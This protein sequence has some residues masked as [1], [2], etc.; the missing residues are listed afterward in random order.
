MSSAA[1]ALGDPEKATAFV[2]EGLESVKDNAQAVALLLG[3]AEVHLSRGD[4]EAFMKTLAR[5]AKRSPTRLDHIATL[6][7]YKAMIARLQGDLD[8]SAAL[9]AT[10]AKKFEAAH[11]WHQAAAMW[12]F[13]AE[14]AVE[15]NP[16]GASEALENASR[17]SLMSFSA[18]SMSDTRLEQVLVFA[19]RSASSQSPLE[20]ARKVLKASVEASTRA[21]RYDQQATALRYGLLTLPATA[22]I[23]KKSK[24]LT[25]ALV[26]AMAGT[27]R[28]EIAM[29]L[30]LKGRLEA[31]RFNFEG[32]QE[33]LRDAEAFAKATG[34]PQLVE[35]IRAELKQLSEQ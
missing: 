33:T 23:N 20:G 22:D 10:S 2:E 1:L 24:I 35:M 21:E 29:L 12:R 14:T 34:D 8:S 15:V 25:D 9:Y 17:A 4:L 27:N 19:T 26:P 32:A 16:A 28:E 31:A 18:Q 11:H 7:R 5:T 30:S 3:L 6:D 13:M